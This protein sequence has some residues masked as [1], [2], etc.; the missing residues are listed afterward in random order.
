MN[1][2][3]IK[4]KHGHAL[5]QNKNEFS[6]SFFHCDNIFMIITFPLFLMVIFF[7]AVLK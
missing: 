4:N 5:H 7:F 6:V 1:L 2:I 3:K